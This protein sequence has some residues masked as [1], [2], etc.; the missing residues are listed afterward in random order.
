MVLKKM[1]YRKEKASLPP[2]PLIPK[3]PI[4]LQRWQLLI[5]P[6]IWIQ[7][8][9]KITCIFSKILCKWFHTVLH[10]IF[11]HKIVYLRD[12]SIFSWLQFLDMIIY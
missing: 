3:S 9:K 5:V 6:C 1:K 10:F 7:W 2:Y 12:L 4:P 8:G 11:F